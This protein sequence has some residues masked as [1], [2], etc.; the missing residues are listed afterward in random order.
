VRFI[1]E[2][3]PA[4]P[5]IKAKKKEIGLSAM[6]ISLQNEIKDVTETHKY[7]ELLFCQ[8]VSSSSI[9]KYFDSKDR[10][11]AAINKL[12]YR[13]Y[14]CVETYIGRGSTIRS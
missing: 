12:T 6:Y 14:K 9:T 11:Y 10:F 1:L 3:I 5:R 2:F 7:L 4:R 13:N 8:F